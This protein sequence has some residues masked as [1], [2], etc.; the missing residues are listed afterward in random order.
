VPAPDPGVDAV[1]SC[2]AGAAADGRPEWPAAVRSGLAEGS[3]PAGAAAP[4]G[5]GSERVGP[6]RLSRGVVPAP[7]LVVLAA[8][9]VQGGAGVAVRIIDRAGPLVA[10]WLRLGLG[11]VLLAVVRPPWRSGMGRDAWRTAILFGIVLA[12]MNGA[13]YVAIGRIPLGVAVTFEFWGPLAVAVA[14]S[15]R[16]LDLVWVALAAV[17]IFTLAGGRLAADDMIGV[18]FALAAGGCWAL[19]ILIGSRLTK[20]WPDGRGLG[21]AMLVG[22]GLLAVP[23]V[24]TGGSWLLQPWILGAGLVVALFSSV[25]PYTLELA[26]MRSLPPGVFGVL[27]SLDPAFAALVGLLFLGQALNLPEALAIGLVIVASAGT[28]LAHARRPAV[29]DQPL[30]VAD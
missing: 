24:A 25:I 17:G 1:P 16:P 22:G 13:F 3:G 2:E 21:V 29:P 23:A 27:T 12:S 15:R 19:Y 30:V 18:A 26:A 11:A 10:V 8:I 5:P 7:L 28:S 6:S 14:G 9:S 20:A 4:P